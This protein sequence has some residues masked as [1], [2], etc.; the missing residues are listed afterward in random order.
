MLSINDVVLPSPHSLSVKITP[1]TGSTQY[2]TRGQLLQDGVQE[3]RTVEIVW[4]RLNQDD[5][6]LLAGQLNPG[7]FFTCNYPDPLK[8]QTEITCR[9]SGQQ[10][11]V[12]HYQPAAPLWADVKLILEE[13]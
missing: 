6:S 1:K 7:G 12:Y 11:T 4:V 5:L 9:L 3:K 10:A 8:G 13:Q 2:N